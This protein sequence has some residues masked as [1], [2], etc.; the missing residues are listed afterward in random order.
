ML[1]IKLFKMKTI[2]VAFVLSV[3]FLKIFSHDFNQAKMDSL[4]AK[5]DSA[6]K[7][8]GSISIFKSDQE[9]Y[10]YVF[11]YADFENEKKI[12]HETKFRIG[13]VS[14]SFTAVIVMKLIEEGK[15]SLDTKL[16]EFYPDIP[17]A[18]K[19][20]I[21][22]LLRHRSGLTD[23]TKLR[24]YVNW[25]TK[26]KPKNEFLE[27]IK[28][29]RIAFNPNEKTKYS[30]TNYELLAFIVE[31]VTGKPFSQVIKEELIIS[32]G[33]QNTSYG[34]KINPERN[35]ALSYYKLDPWKKEI[36]T[37]LSLAVGSGAV[38]SN[39]YDINLF[40]YKLFSGKIISRESL[41]EMQTVIDNFGIGLMFTQFY[42]KSAYGHNGSIDGFQ[43]RSA[44][45]P[46]D[47]IAVTYL[48]NAIDIPVNDI[49]FGT[50]SI[51][52]DKNYTLPEFKEEIDS[53]STD[54]Y[55]YTGVYTT[56][57][58]PLDITITSDGNS[59]TAQATNQPSF[60]LEPYAL[61]KFKFD[62]VSLTM[63][64][65]PEKNK[66]ILRQFGGTIEFRRIAKTPLKV[67]E[68]NQIKHP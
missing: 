27:I 22:Y 36:E 68:E 9:I 30:N 3:F 45:F 66:M 16:S 62:Q 35:E 1:T 31:E 5:I 2:S 11:G 49:L 7:G 59:L 12:D 15:L 40:Y 4:F 50:L 65:L 61:H 47:S 63:E 25:I 28:R 33:L 34:G 14:K 18:D 48:T 41:Y 17:N 8:M 56:P 26:Y 37:N 60:V 20:K 39:P 57:D 64:F 21:E 55:Q 51:L 44:F 46:E 6:G 42:D 19:I 58:F 43:A 13:S 23:F 10:H 53:I 67:H 29:S 38:A 24:D 32:L 54:F 52:F